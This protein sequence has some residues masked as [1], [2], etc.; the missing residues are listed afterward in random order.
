MQ[1]AWIEPVSGKTL[2]YN[3][4][5]YYGNEWSACSGVDHYKK[6]T[7]LLM[8]IF[9]NRCPLAHRFSY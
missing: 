2:W 6:P 5:E 1:I 4:G 7:A 9:G 8:A 3:H